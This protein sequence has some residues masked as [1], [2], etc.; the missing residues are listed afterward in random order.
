[1][2]RSDGTENWLIYDTERDPHNVTDEALLPNT[3][4][5][6]GGSANAMDILSNGFKFRATSG[7]LNASGGNYI[8][9]AIASQPFKFSNAR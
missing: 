1:M 3:S 8:Y 2:K 7:S 9:L 6:S 4:G 5:S